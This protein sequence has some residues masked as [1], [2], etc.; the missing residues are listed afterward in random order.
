MS[1]PLPLLVLEFLGPCRH[2]RGMLRYTIAHQDPRIVQR[3]VGRENRIL[4]KFGRFEFAVWAF[5]DFQLMSTKPSVLALRG[6][7]TFMDTSDFQVP[8]WDR[9]DLEEAVRIF[10]ETFDIDSFG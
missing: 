3:M 8:E 10:N 5:P 1:N 4:G 2:D 6:E 9:Q 7:L